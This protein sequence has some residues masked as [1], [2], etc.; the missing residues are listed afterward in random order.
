MELAV[1]KH[2][3]AEL[4][5]LVDYLIDFSTFNSHQVWIE[6]LKVETLWLLS[7]STRF[8]QICQD[9]DDSSFYHVLDRF[10]IWGHVH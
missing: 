9:F 10:A 4:K 3:K 6:H 1:L 2:C 5:R 7:K 8:L